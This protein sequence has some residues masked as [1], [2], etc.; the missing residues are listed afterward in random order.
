MRVRRAR[1]EDGP[2]LARIANAAWSR[3]SSILPRPRADQDVFRAPVH[4]EHVL[5]AL[6]GDVPVGFIKLVPTAAAEP[7]LVTVSGHVDRVYGLSV[8][9]EHQGRGAGTAL[10]RAARAE[11]LARGSR[12]I[13]MR[14]LS[15][16][17]RAQRLY[18]RLGY[19]VE[20]VLHEEFL[21]DG[22]YVDDVLLAL[23]L[24]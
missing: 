17:A 21:V 8:A 7:R 1:R 13:T 20:G 10:L 22:A 4:P 18:E 14:V 11:A 15:S 5:V 19:Q 16:N 23:D 6:T 2:D 24:T 9:P 3:E 12:R